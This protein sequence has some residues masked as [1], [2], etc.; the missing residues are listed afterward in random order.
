MARAPCINIHRPG[1]FL[2]PWS[3]RSG[4]RLAAPARHPS[5]TT[6]RNE[7]LL[8][9]SGVVGDPFVAHGET[10]RLF[11]APWSLAYIFRAQTHA[12]SLQASS[13]HS[14][15]IPRRQGLTLL[16]SGIHPLADEPVHTL[17]ACHSTSCS[18]PRRNIINTFM[19]TLDTKTV[20]HLS[21]YDM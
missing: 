8:I 9:G 13:L 7:T 1:L 17:P 12:R 21:M 4:L 14:K 5:S 18:H 2:S 16:S 6:N 19:P 3:T 11:T 20:N 15:H 10:R